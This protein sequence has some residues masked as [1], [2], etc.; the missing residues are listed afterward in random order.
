M[1]LNWRETTTIIVLE[2]QATVSR[3]TITETTVNRDVITGN[4]S[5]IGARH[6][7]KADCSSRPIPVLRV[8]TAPQND[9]YRFEETTYAVERKPGDSRVAC[10]GKK[11][12]AVGVHYK[13]KADFTGADNTVIDVDFKNGTVRRF[14]FKITVR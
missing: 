6:T 5:P 2:A 12:D 10:N 3:R 9:E 13:S 1:R 14:N 11:V 7:V 4:E 8:I